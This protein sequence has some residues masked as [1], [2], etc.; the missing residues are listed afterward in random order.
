VKDFKPKILCL[1]VTMMFN[2][3]ALQRIAAAVR[4]HSSHS[5]RI[6]AGG[7]A[8]RSFSPDPRPFGVDAIASDVASAVALA[9]DTIAA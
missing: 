7:G 5:M 4:Q 9:R 8:F 3:P 6:I 1:S 2:L